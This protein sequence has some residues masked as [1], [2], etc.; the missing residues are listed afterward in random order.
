MEQYAG[1]VGILFICV[2]IV[3]YMSWDRLFPQD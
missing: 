1:D 2:L 3:V